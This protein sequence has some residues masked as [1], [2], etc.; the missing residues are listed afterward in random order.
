[1]KPY[2][3]IFNISVCAA[4]SLFH[5]TERMRAS[6]DID[7]R[8]DEDSQLDLKLHWAQQVIRD[9][10]QVMQMLMQRGL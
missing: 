8:F 2:I 4:L 6:D 3:G 5:L 7:W 10:E 1:M 9:G